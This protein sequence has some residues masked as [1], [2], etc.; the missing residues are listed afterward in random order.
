MMGAFC[1]VFGEVSFGFEFCVVLGGLSGVFG[2]YCLV[3]L[4]MGLEKP[5]H[6]GFWG[7]WAVGSA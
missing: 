1:I 5:D 6:L 7:F 4:W 2:W 3:D